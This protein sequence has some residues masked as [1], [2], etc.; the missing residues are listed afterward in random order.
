VGESRSVP[1][2]R[3][4]RERRKSSLVDVESCTMLGK[5]TWESELDH[6]PS[7]SSDGKHWMHCWLHPF[8]VTGFSVVGAQRDRGGV[9]HL[10]DAVIKRHGRRCKA[11]ELRT[12]FEFEF[13]FWG[14]GGHCEGKRMREE[15]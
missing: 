10:Q 12:K 6:L 4:R 5:E 14:G 13:K 2:A 3:Q 15:L 11:Y 7:Q 1:E 8:N 9:E